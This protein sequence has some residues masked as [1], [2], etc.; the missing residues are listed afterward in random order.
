LYFPA[1]KHSIRSTSKIS[2]KT[3][4]GT[5]FTQRLATEM[6]CKVTAVPLTVISSYTINEQNYNLLNE[7]YLVEIVQL[8]IHTVPVKT[9]EY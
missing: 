9:G 8:F 1:I 4:N 2:C 6:Q 3:Q 7:T 5:K